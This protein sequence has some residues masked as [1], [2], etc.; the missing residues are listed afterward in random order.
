MVPTYGDEAYFSVTGGIGTAIVFQD[1]Y[2][3]VATS[4]DFAEPGDPSDLIDAALAQLK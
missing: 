1:D 4:I 2:W 3:L